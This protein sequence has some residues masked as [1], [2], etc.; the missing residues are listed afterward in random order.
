[1]AS[2]EKLGELY[3]K[4]RADLDQLNKEIK[5]LKNK[6]DGEAEK[7]GKSFGNTITTAIKSVGVLYILQKAFDFGRTIIQTASQFEQLKTR[8]TSLYGSAEKAS[9][10]FDQFKKIAAT[11]PF[12]LQGVVEA[13][14]NLKAFGMDAEKTL[15]GVTDLAAFMGL[16]VVEASAAVGRAFAGGVGAADVL[17]ERGVLNLIKSFKGIEDLSKLTLPEFRQALISSMQDPMLGIAGST[18]RLSQTLEGSFSNLMDSL[19]NTMAEIGSRAIPMLTSLAKVLTFTK[20]SFDEATESAGKERAEFDQLAFT[21][22]KL[23]QNVSLTEAQSKLYQDTINK[24][25]EKFPEYFKNINLEKDSYNNVK[26]AIDNARKSLEEYLKLKVRESLLT[27][28]TNAIATNM[29]DQIKG[30]M[31]IADLERRHKN[32]EKMT[33]EVE[34]PQGSVTKTQSLQPAINTARERV[35]KLQKEARVLKNEVLNIQNTIDEAFGTTIAPK[36]TPPTAPTTTSPTND[37]GNK[38][39][40]S[41]KEEFLEKAKFLD[42]GYYDFRIE[43]INKEAEAEKKLGG[44]LA[45]IEIL[46]QN[47]IDALNKERDN[48]NI[49]S[50]NFQSMGTKANFGAF[51]LPSEEN[52][53]QAEEE[54][55]A[56]NKIRMQADL[57]F[58]NTRQQL[59]EES[60]I[61]MSEIY[62]A[63]YQSIT[64]GLETMFTGFWSGIKL[65]EEQSKNAMIA[66]FTQMANS[67]I[68]AVQRMA[69]EWL[70]FQVLRGIFG[71]AT[72]G[73]GTAI[74][75]GA[76]PSGHTGGEFL[77]T[78]GGIVKMARGGSFVVPPGFPS[79]S[80]PMLVESGERVSVTPASQTRYSDNAML[81]ELQGVKSAIMALNM[82]MVGSQPSSGK[83]NIEL[84]ST[85]KGDDIYMTNKNF[86]KKV[87]RYS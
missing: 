77:G 40:L 79:D 48:Y 4:V 41:K 39:A 81:S 5:G 63:G 42:K 18:D 66:G 19:A 84:E 12:S 64:G 85:I 20:S 32:G 16:D 21:Y 36:V 44:S 58:F 30:E 67:F 54:A 13:G 11:T 28:K 8:L 68:A 55:K 45:A 56:L 71:V 52:L 80:Y 73:I 1:M 3:V 25:N 33:Y 2:D 14:A 17:R 76:T 7:I 82:N 43:Q 61:T 29:A 24:L 69:A 74:A 60:M 72:G 49:K 6:M 37:E 83:A 78:N 86:A 75:G 59:A 46:K 22:L 15:K 35:Y 31:E 50:G 87:N 65:S 26:G 23:K 62:T 27:D 9:V 53:R 70:A 38:K 47:K 10:V 57:E 34:T 51:G